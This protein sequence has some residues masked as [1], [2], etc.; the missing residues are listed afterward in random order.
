MDS[1][2]TPYRMAEYS[3]F[4]L[5]IINTYESKSF[6]EN[7]IFS[8]KF[9]RFLALCP[10][11]LHVFAVYDFRPSELMLLCKQSVSDKQLNH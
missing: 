1:S 7:N 10:F 9:E 4:W 5:I 8:E 2:W 6:F 3:L 11:Q